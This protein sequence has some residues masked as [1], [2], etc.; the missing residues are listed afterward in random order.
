MREDVSPVQQVLRHEP[1]PFVKGSVPGFRVASIWLGHVDG[2][3][4]DCP[5]DDPLR[6]HVASS[7][8]AYGKLVQADVFTTGTPNRGVADLHAA[9]VRDAVEGVGQLVLCEV[10]HLFC[11]ARRAVVPCAGCSKCLDAGEIARRTCRDGDQAGT[12]EQVSSSIR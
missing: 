11:A 3:A 10:A 9:T 6:T 5:R 4:Q 2:F 7:V 8:T 12:V 1:P